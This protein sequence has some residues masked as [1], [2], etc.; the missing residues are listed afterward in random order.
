LPN[1]FF[2]IDLFLDLG[3]ILNTLFLHDE[4]GLVIAILDELILDVFVHH[5]ESIFNVVLGPTWHLFY[6]FGPFVSYG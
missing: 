6:D 4:H 2:L 1:E 5:V 3:R